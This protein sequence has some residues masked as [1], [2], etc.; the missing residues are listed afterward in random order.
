M[1]KIHLIVIVIE[2]PK[3]ITLPNPEGNWHVRNFRPPRTSEL[4]PIEDFGMPQVEYQEPYF[5]DEKDIPEVG[6]DYGG[7]THK[8]NSRKISN[9]PRYNET[10]HNNSKL[11]NESFNQISPNFRCWEIS[12]R[13]PTRSEAIKWLEE[14]KTVQNL[15]FVRR[16]R[17]EEPG[18]SSQVNN[19]I[20]VSRN[21]SN[22]V[23]QIEGPT[24]KNKHGFKLSQNEKSKCINN[25]LQ[26][27]S[28][29][30]LE[31]HGIL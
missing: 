2:M 31:V 30:S 26:P 6:F 14:K 12:A 13:P 19:F 27:L 1:A 7:V 29:M 22:L 11:L 15:S 21:S 8:F 17:S 23:V 10:E 20:S 3:N 18:H 28:I 5:S 9:V 16:E 24:Q 25:E 4:V